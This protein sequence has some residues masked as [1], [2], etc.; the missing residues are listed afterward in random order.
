MSI[1]VSKSG[2]L[3]KQLRY[4]RKF[5]EEETKFYIMEIILA[6]ESLHQSH[7]VYRDL[8]PA[9][10]VLDS[11]GHIKLTDFGLSKQGI[12]DNSTNSFCGFQ[13]YNLSYNNNHFIAR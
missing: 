1:S 3:E 10:I 8:K 9:N 6:L 13:F 7:I 5:T 4:R 2:D 11:E 12:E